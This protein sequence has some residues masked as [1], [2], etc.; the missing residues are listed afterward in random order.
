M[1]D[2]FS[3]SPASPVDDDDDA[4][5]FPAKIADDEVSESISFSVWQERIIGIANQD[6]YF[7]LASICQADQYFAPQ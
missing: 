6:E 3:Y 1:K 7:E 4:F 2:E 5:V